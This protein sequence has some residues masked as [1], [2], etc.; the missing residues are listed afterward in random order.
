[1]ID[2]RVEATSGSRRGEVTVRRKDSRVWS[3]PRISIEETEQGS[4]EL[5][6]T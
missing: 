2:E 6:W 5:R 1:M 4:V 3:A